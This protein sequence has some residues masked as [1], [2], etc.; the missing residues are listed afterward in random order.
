MGQARVITPHGFFSRMM[1]ESCNFR[2]KDIAT[3]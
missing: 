3:V 1:Q 2:Y